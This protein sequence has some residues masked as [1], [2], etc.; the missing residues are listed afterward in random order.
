[1]LLDLEDPVRIELGCNKIMG[2]D[3]AGGRDELIGFTEGRYE[4][5]WPLWYYLGVAESA[6][7]NLDTAIQDLKKVLVLS[8]SNTDVMDELAQLYEAAGDTAN[9]AKYRNKISVVNHNKEL[10]NL[11][12]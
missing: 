2:G 4:N 5:W 6:L 8:P 9:A 1:M 3:F 11:R 10:D 12:S 7:G